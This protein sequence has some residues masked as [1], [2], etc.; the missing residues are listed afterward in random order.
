MARGK[1]SKRKRKH[2][3]TV[4]TLTRSARSW[5][6]ARRSQSW[7]AFPQV[8]V[9]RTVFLITNLVSQREGQTQN[10]LIFL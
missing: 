8:E 6:N 2:R 7:G 9:A 5:A 10:G 4:Q 1:S 3:R